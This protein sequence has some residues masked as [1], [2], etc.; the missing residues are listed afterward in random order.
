MALT[1]MQISCAD[2]K[3]KNKGKLTLP[4]HNILCNMSIN[5]KILRYLL[6]GTHAGDSF[7]STVGGAITDW[8]LWVRL[9]KLLLL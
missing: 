1:V 2:F 3:N 8:S 4:E 6:S 9:L 7:G 5:N